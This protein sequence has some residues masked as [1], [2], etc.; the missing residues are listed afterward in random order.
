MVYCFTNT[1]AAYKVTLISQNVTSSMFWRCLL[2]TVL[3]ASKT[4][5][6]IALLTSVVCTLLSRFLT[7]IASKFDLK[8]GSSKS[9]IFNCCSDKTG[10]STITLLFVKT[11]YTAILSRRL[12][13]LLFPLFNKSFSVIFG[14]LISK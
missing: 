11:S 7:F 1:A 2:A 3:I 5:F 6:D 8:I 10:L 12:Y 13:A 9:I 4:S 14:V